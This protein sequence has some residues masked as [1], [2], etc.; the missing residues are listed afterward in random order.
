MF[1]AIA[2]VLVYRMVVG[3]YRISRRWRADSHPANRRAD[4]GS[5]TFRQWP[6]R[7]LNSRSYQVGRPEKVEPLGNAEQFGQRWRFGP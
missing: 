4:F 2:A 5:N 1:I 3:N 7:S 6:Q